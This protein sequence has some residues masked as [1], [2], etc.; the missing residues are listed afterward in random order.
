MCLLISI[1]KRLLIKVVM[2]YARD[3][4]NRMPAGGRNGI[5][6]H[7][8]GMRYT[9]QTLPEGT[10]A[11]IPWRDVAKRMVAW[12]GTYEFGASTTKRKWFELTRRKRSF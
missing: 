11:N 3:S 2:K 12:G 10:E 8:P 1:Q 9:V 4:L 6:G 5:T 7:H